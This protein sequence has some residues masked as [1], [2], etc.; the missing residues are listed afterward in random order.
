MVLEA[1]PRFLSGENFAARP[2]RKVLFYK[3]VGLPGGP[4]AWYTPYVPGP[5]VIAP[6]GYADRRPLILDIDL[7]IRETFIILKHYVVMRTVFFY[8]LAL[9]YESGD[10]SF[11]NHEF[12]PVDAFHH[13]PG[14]FG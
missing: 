1:R 13:L 14:F 10:L 12:N 11:G 4:R 5:I 3:L 7:Y 9:K 8:L 6:P 2:Q